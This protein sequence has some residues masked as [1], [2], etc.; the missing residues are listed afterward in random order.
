[1]TFTETA[2]I[3][4]EQ[5]LGIDNQVL[6][7]NAW[8]AALTTMLVF[9]LL[10][11][12][13]HLI[14]KGLIKLFTAR[15]PSVLGNN[16]VNTVRSPIMWS[17]LVTGMALSLRHFDAPVLLMQRFDSSM[18]TIML[19]LWSACLI[20]SSR[21]ILK[22]MS[23]ERKG[24]S[25]IIRQQT[26]PLFENFLFIVILVYATYLLFSA[27]GIDLTAWIASAGVVGIAIGFAAKDTLANLI[28][29]VFIMADAPYKLGDMVV[30]ETLERGEITHIGLR[31]TR[32]FTTDHAEITIPNAVMGNSKVI[33]ESG[34]YH[35]KSRIRLP[36]GVAY[37]SDVDKVKQVLLDVA[38]GHREV[39]S[40]PEHRV[41]F[42]VFGTSSLD[43]ELLCWI[44][45]PQSRGRIIDEL[46]TLIY[47]AFHEN[48]VEIPYAKQDVYIRS[49]PHDH[50]KQTENT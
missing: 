32:M 8:A 24:R 31:S 23:R 38:C 22:A 21:M 3:K 26:L 47:K 20:K 50:S 43:F 17:A 36:V 1:M 29:G 16:L 2:I 25:S 5:I 27:W 11:F 42:R 19:I 34:G 10:A 44:T 28:S 35:Q 9:I 40:L 7:G 4:L 14:A 13:A 12:I 18:L 45:D 48:K 46:N 30:L 37:G 15:F 33:N 6:S 39:C 41:R 49:V